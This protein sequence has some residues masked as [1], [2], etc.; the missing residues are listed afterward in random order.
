[1]LA[2]RAKALL[3]DKTDYYALAARVSGL[4]AP[5]VIEELAEFGPQPTETDYRLLTQVKGNGLVRGVVGVA[6]AS[7]FLRQA[8][9]DAKR[10]RD[11]AYVAELL[12]QQFRVEVG[13]NAVAL[14]HPVDGARFD[15]ENQAC[16]KELVFCGAL[17]QELDTIQDDLLSHGVYTDR[18]EISSISL[19]AGLQSYLRYLGS[20]SAVLV[21]ELLADQTHVRIITAN[22][23]G[24]TRSL[25][26]GFNS[27]LPVVRSELGLKDEESARK[28][29]FSNSFDFTT[30]G[31]QLIRKL[32]RDLQ[33]A[34]GFYEVQT[35]QSIGHVFMPML[36]PNLRWLGRSFAEGLGV[37]ALEID[38]PGWLPAA[39][40]QL[41]NPAM[42]S[43][44]DNRWM[45]LFSLV[46]FQAQAKNNPAPTSDGKAT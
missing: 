22:G 28:V 21:L 14:L 31:A 9:V 30:K 44:V 39:G 24:A 15:P 3:L 2:K 33:S 35:G 38:F 25:V 20:T 23:L 1:M 34:V 26:T 46:A 7:R 32:V 4:V 29:F 5:V 8:P 11:A 13:K 27:F 10:I 6:P 12:N 36:P 45:A 40:I 43:Q 37:S 41:A 18:L 19:V 16:P 42:L 17:R